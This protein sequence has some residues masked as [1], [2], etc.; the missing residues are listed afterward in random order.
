[1]PATRKAIW[2]PPSGDQG[3]GGEEGDRE[4]ERGAGL[5][6]REEA[7]VQRLRA[8]VGEQQ[9]VVDEREAVAEAAE[10]EGRER[11]ARSWCSDGAGEQVDG[12]AG[13]RRPGRRG[14]RPRRRRGEARGRA[15][16]AT[17]PTP[18]AVDHHGQAGAADVEH[19]AREDDLADVGDPDAEHDAGGGAE[20]RAD[21][22]AARRARGCPRAR[23]RTATAAAVGAPGARRAAARR[24]RRDQ[25]AREIA[26]ETALRPISAVGRA[27]PPAAAA[28]SAG[29]A[30]RPRS[31]IAPKRPIAAARRSSPSTRRGSPA[32]A[33]GVNSAVPTPAS[34]R[35]DDHH[36]QRVR[37]SSR[38]TNAAQ[39]STSATTA[40]ARQ[41]TRSTS[42]PSSGP[43]TIAGQQV[44]QQHRGDRPRRSRSGR[45]PAAAARRSARPVPRQDWACAAKKRRA[46][47]PDS[48]APEHQAGPPARGEAPRDEPRAAGDVH[49]HED[50]EQQHG[51]ADAEDVVQRE[52]RR[53][54][55]TTSP[56][57]CSFGVLED[58][59]LANSPSGSARGERR[60]RV[61][62]GGHDAAVGRDR[63]EVQQPAERDD[64]RRPRSW[65]LDER[66]RAEQH[67]GEHVQ[68]G[69]ERVVAR[70]GGPR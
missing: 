32:S 9:A 41:P 47:A 51:V 66:E 70:S 36:R 33:A 13:E 38:S 56:R 27:R 16:R 5:L 24:D 63:D 49:E 69:V 22:G 59:E 10:R 6:Q 42:A 30:V 58:R 45:R 35:A 43:S 20:Q 44:G 68:R 50:A 62:V 15:S 7:A 3:A 23:R 12:H 28:A 34:A 11:R 4:G 17:V 18:P 25:A 57:K 67:V 40:H 48:A 31:S 64:R 53:G 8:C 46:G 55:R 1:M 29:P 54:W 61:R 19:L 14:A 26:N 37:R 21:L 65:R 2:T 39:R 60:D 52:R